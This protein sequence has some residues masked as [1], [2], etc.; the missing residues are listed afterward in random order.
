MTTTVNTTR[1]E[2]EGAVLPNQDYHSI[3]SLGKSES[4]L[5]RV[6]VEREIYHAEGVIE[7][8]G[9]FNSR[10][11]GSPHGRIGVEG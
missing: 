9:V 6:R 10:A 2:G 5:A 8:E 4:S 11:G 1:F 3:L 7:R